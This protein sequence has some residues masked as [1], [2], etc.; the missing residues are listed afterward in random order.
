MG[1][2]VTTTTKMCNEKYTEP[3]SR[4]AL[5]MCDIVGVT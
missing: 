4:E 5:Q 2:K 3:G 1:L